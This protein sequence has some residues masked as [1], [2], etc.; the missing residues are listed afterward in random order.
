MISVLYR[1]SGWRSFFVASAQRL[2]TLISPKRV[3]VNVLTNAPPMATA[4][5]AS[6]ASSLPIRRRLEAVFLYSFFR[7]LAISGGLLLKMRL[8]L[9][10]FLGSG[11]LLVSFKLWNLIV[12]PTLSA[13]GPKEQIMRT[14]IAIL[15][16]ALL[17]IGPASAE[18]AKSVAPGQHA[19]G[20]HGQPGASYYAPGHEKKRL[21]MQSA[22][23]LAPG[24]EK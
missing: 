5:V 18:S 21:H 3:F 12:C 13:L 22:R 1:R 2:T 9:W 24:H 19:K 16:L 17:A 8:E 7:E 4:E 6:L 11:R 14:T 23:R 15:T 10:D 20:T